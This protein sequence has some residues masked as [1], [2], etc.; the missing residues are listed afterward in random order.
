MG[1]FTR[2]FCATDSKPKISEILE[3]LKFKGFDVNVELSESKF[4]SD[5]WTNFELIYDSEKLPLLIELNEIN[6]PDGFAEEEIS[7]FIEYIGKPNFLELNKKIIIRHLKV[8]QYIVCIE[9]PTSDITDEGYDLNGELMHYLE[10][11]FSGLTQADNEGFY[12]KN[13]LLIKI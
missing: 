2:V 7:E 9:L 3:T 1:Y 6:K 13:K 8:T 4:K 11:N 12:L 10:V 5:D